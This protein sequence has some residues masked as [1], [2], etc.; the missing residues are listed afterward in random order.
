MIARPSRILALEPFF[1]EFI[2]GVEAELSARSVA[3]TIQ[4]VHDPEEEVEVYRRWWGERRVDGVMLIDLRVDDPRVAEIER[5]GLPAVVVGGPLEGDVVPSV[6]HDEAAAVAEV[7]RYLAA[8]G[9]ERIARVAG[10]GDLRPQR[11][12]QPRPSGRPPPSAA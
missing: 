5:L 7:V 2:A 1:M 8:L 10:V 3:L 12:A 4:L 6:W 11:A 9:H